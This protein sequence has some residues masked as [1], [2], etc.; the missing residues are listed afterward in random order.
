MAAFLGAPV[1]AKALLGSAAARKVELDPEDAHA[2]AKEGEAYVIQAIKA[3][4]PFQPS[5][6][7][8]RAKLEE[9]ER[10]A[11]RQAA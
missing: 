5:K 4:P 2:I 1:A 8:H 9:I 6:P 10:A 11:K 3:V 7:K